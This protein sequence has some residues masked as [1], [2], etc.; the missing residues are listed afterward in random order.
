MTDKSKIT[1]AS[2]NSAGRPKRGKIPP[3]PPASSF[4]KPQEAPPIEFHSPVVYTPSTES[5]K[6]FYERAKAAHDKKE[7][8]R[9]M[10]RLNAQVKNEICLLIAMGFSDRYI[11]SEINDHFFKD[12][13]EEPPIHWT[14]ISKI[15]RHGGKWRG[16]IKTYK[17]IHI[18]ASS[19]HQVSQAGW[20]LKILQQSI[21]Q[22]SEQ[23]KHSAVAALIRVAMEAGGDITPPSGII[24]GG[25]VHIH[26]T[27]VYQN[28]K[29]EELKDKSFV[30][31]INTHNDCISHQRS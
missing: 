11:A 28:I 29:P 20:R 1:R 6:D 14:T 19:R 30:D 15:Y 23:K 22:A 10:R 16:L 5:D 18:Q 27:K 24:A 9:Y 7:N 8:N 12:K 21:I 26:H 17:K 2:D 3:K 13:P 31:L 4:T 25:D